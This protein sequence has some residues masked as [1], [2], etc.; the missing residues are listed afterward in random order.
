MAP[1]NLGAVPLEVL[2][3]I[4]SYLDTPSYCALRL[5]CKGIEAAVFRTFAQKYFR[6]IRFMRTEFSLQALVDISKSRLSTYLQHVIISTRLLCPK[7]SFSIK[8]PPMDERDNGLVKFNQLCSDQL[9][10][11]E[12]SY[13][14]EMLVEAF[15]NLNLQVVEVS[16]HTLTFFPSRIPVAYGVSHILRETSVDVKLDDISNH[17]FHR[18]LNTSCV[19]NVL[20][21]LGKAGSRPKRFEIEIYHNKFDDDTLN[22]PNF[23]SKAVSPVLSSLEA[24]EIRVGPKTMVSIPSGLVETISDK[25]DTYYL[26]KFLSQSNQIKHLRLEQIRHFDGFFK[27]LT[28]PRLNE[29]CGRFLGPEPAQPPIFAN[30][31]E[32]ELGWFEVNFHDILVVLKR[33]STTLQKLTL[34]DMTLILPD[35]SKTEF[36]EWPKAIASLARNG[37]C[38]QKIHLHRIAIGAGRARRVMVFDDADDFSYAGPNMEKAIGSMVDM[39]PEDDGHAF[40]DLSEDD[41]EELDASD[42]DDLADF[43]EYL[44]YVDEYDDLIDGLDESL[45]EDFMY[46][47]IYGI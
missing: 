30:L 29:S 10:L 23:M 4:T 32:L 31:H 6:K 8:R 16:E 21:A 1:A 33:F 34:H 15:R 9:A 19:Q 17:S 26:R 5:T 12:T 43:E 46:Q 14:Q 20:F 22:I 36:E 35:P 24:I 41:D 37:R 38:L 39:L 47:T 45:A 28:A 2:I 25:L 7:R 3:E 18:K 13:Y 27:W 44:D 40:G 42:D 11:L